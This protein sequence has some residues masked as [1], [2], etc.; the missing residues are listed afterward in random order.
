MRQLISL[1]RAVK[2]IAAVPDGIYRARLAEDYDGIGQ[3]VMVS[4]SNASVGSAFKSRIAA[5]DFGGNRTFPAGTLVRVHSFRGQLET[6]LGNFPGCFGDEFQRSEEGSLGSG[7][8]GEW[9]LTG[10]AA[11]YSVDGGYALFTSKSPNDLFAHATLE[12]SAELPFE[13]LALMEARIG[14]GSIGW[15]GAGTGGTSDFGFNISIGVSTATTPFGSGGIVHNLNGNLFNPQLLGISISD[16]REDDNVNSDFDDVV[17]FSWPSTPVDVGP[18]YCR[19]Y[20]D[21]YGSYAR[22][23]LADQDE[24]LTMNRSGTPSNIIGNVLFPF[25][26]QPSVEAQFRAQNGGRNEPWSC[27][28]VSINP[29]IAPF[30]DRRRFFIGSEATNGAAINALDSLC[31]LQGF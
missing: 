24:P 20:I 18:F 3:Y 7:R 9:T 19:V 17:P 29:R 13:M 26:S 21:E 10:P 22:V 23:W 25:Y 28:D 16:T 6:F 8:L 14:A 15:N 31:I 30:S 1:Q 4:L 2:D 11:Q 5:G 27:Y 12:D